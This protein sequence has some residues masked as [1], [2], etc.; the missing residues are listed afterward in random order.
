MSDAP[1]KELPNPPDGFRELVGIGKPSAPCIPRIARPARQRKGYVPAK[2]KRK[3]DS[4]KT[5]YQAALKAD[6]KLKRE[7]HAY[8]E[9]DPKSFRAVLKKTRARVFK[10]KRGPK[11]DERIAQAAQE[12]VGGAEWQ[13]LYQKHI[14]SYADMRNEVTRDDAESGI[15]RKVNQYRQRHPRL[16]RKLPAET[17]ATQSAT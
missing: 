1:R 14:P 15:R 11:Q 10:L 12:R 6:R 9:A 5:L 13:A 3:R 8:W 16:R 4:T 17:I 7:H 2:R